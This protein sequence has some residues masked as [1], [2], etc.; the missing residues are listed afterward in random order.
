MTIPV[1]LTIVMI[2]SAIV[3]YAVAFHERKGEDLDQRAISSKQTVVV[4]AVVIL[5]AATIP[6][7]LGAGLTSA[8]L[9]SAS[10]T[11]EWYERWSFV[12]SPVG[13]LFWWCSAGQVFW[14]NFVS[15]REVKAGHAGVILAA[16]RRLRRAHLY[17]GTHYLPNWFTI[18]QVDM[19][20]G[21]SDTITFTIVSKDGIEMSA[22][23]FYFRRI[24]DPDNYFDNDRPNE[25]LEGVFKSAARDTGLE[26]TKDE[27]MRPGGKGTLA[28][29]VTT[30][31]KA[32]H[33]SLDDG[34]ID[35]RF[36]AENSILASIENLTPPAEMLT[37]ASKKAAEQDLQDQQM[38]RL[39]AF[40]NRFK[41]FMEANPKLPTEEA[42]RM[43]MLQEGLTSA[44]EFIIRGLEGMGPVGAALATQI[45]R[46]KG[47]GKKPGKQGEN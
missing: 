40:S 19:T 28:V 8:L 39:N 26:S 1:I 4:T 12:L 43:F 17:E 44:E 47:K 38:I 15:L 46:N 37:A 33:E 7:I 32:Y 23:G 22:E 31:V 18:L 6:G 10:R 3:A 20:Q 2:L 16:G 29:E 30:A 45:Q 34:R 11:P 25:T 36:L 42:A 35:R 24:E 5:A 21:K 9:H 27:L 41:V 14:N 13:F